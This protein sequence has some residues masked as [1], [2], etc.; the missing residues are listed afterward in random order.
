M[1]LMVLFS[2]KEA[3]FQQPIFSFYRQENQ[4]IA[5]VE[6]TEIDT[7]E[8]RNETLRKENSKAREIYDANYPKNDDAEHEETFNVGS[9]AENIETTFKYEKLDKVTDKENNDGLSGVSID[10]HSKDEY[11]DDANTICGDEQKEIDNDV[12]CHEKNHNG[13]GRA[14]HKHVACILFYSFK[15]MFYYVCA[16]KK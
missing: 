2:F 6:Y 8:T 15:M 16:Y 11:P 5:K 13:K 4:G 10:T 9:H 3:K 12:R 7:V 14:L 1:L